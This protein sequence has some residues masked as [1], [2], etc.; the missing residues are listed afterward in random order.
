MAASA[1]IPPTPQPDHSEAVDH[2]RVRI[3]ADQ[4]VGIQPFAVVP[5]HLGQVLEVDL[6]D[7]PGGR[8]HHPEVGEGLLAPLEELVALLV[9]LELPPTVD[10]QS[11]RTVEG[12]DLDRMVDDE[13]GRDPR[14]DL[15]R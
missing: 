1:S 3:G 7:D 8:R 4:G 14:V 12:V 15:R 13:I 11:I 10:H 5:D 6:V 2:G 9:P